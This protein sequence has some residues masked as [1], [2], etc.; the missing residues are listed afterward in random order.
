MLFV[1]N[2]GYSMTEYVVIT[3]C[4]FLLVLGIINLI[5]DKNIDVLNMNITESKI[6]KMKVEER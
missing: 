2:K 5:K 4:I 1:N 6:I 3:G